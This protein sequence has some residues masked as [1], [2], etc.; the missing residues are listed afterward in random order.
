M[1]YDNKS[2]QVR[3]I[4]SSLYQGILG[5][6]ADKEGLN[7]YIDAL[8][9]GALLSEVIHEIVTSEEFRSHQ[10]PTLSNSITLPNLTLLYPDKYIRKDVNSSIFEATSDADF[11]LMESLISKH[12]YYDSFGVWAPTID[13]DKRVTAAIVQGLGALS[14]IELGCF[15]GSVLSILADKG[16]DVCGIELSHLAFVLAHTNIYSKMRFGNFLDLRFDRNFDLFLGMDILEHINP[17]D[18]EK[19]VERISQ[20]VKTSGFA[21]INS[22]MFGEDDVF[23][24]VFDAYLPEWQQAGEDLNW[25]HMHCDAKGWPMHGHLVWASPNWWEKIFLKHGLVRER[26]IERVIHEQLKDFFVAHAP[27][28]R[29]FFVL[30]HSSYKPHIDSLISNMKNSLLSVLPSGN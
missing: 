26:A 19:Y 12:R 1:S 17:L 9:R 3:D 29:S 20:L 25:L 4:V 21:Y 8:L 10:S 11:R 2:Y 14:C 24:T 15:T 5:R 22:P 6:E 18:L 16:V 13:L 27:A 28:R 30:R 7:S 23:G